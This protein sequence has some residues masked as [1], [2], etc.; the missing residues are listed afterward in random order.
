MQRGEAYEGSKIKE[1]IKNLEEVAKMAK[2]FKYAKSF[3]VAAI[4]VALIAALLVGSVLPAKAEPG[5]VI[6][7][8]VQAILTGPVAS[9]HLYLNYGTFDYFRYVNE[10]GGLNGVLIEDTWYDSRAEPAR[11][12]TT[13]RRFM[14]EGV[15]LEVS[16]ADTTIDP[17]VPSLPRDQIPVIM[18]GGS[19]EAMV[20]KPKPW[21]FS[22]SWPWG[23]YIP[24]VLMYIKEQWTEERPPRV[25]LMTID[26]S[27]IYDVLETVP[28]YAS[29]IGI[30][31]IGAELPS[32]FGTLD[33]MTEWMRLLSKNP[34][35]IIMGSFGQTQ[36][37]QLKNAATLEVAKK[38]IK[39]IGVYTLTEL[40]MAIA[41][42][43]ILEGWLVMRHMPS[44]TET[45]L[46]GMKAVLD[47]AKK[48]RGK[49]ATTEYVL[50][51]LGGQIAV[52]GIRLAI[53]RV[54]IQNLSGAAV[55]DAL[56]S[57]RDFDTGLIPPVT[58]TN[59]WTIF[60]PLARVYKIHD[61]KILRYS[62]DYMKFPYSLLMPEHLKRFGLGTPPGG[63]ISTYIIT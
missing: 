53:E 57:M 14:T 36:T 19:S 38:G 5:K 45:D 28:E 63:V 7:V 13:H 10:K 4:P 56:A 31:W 25:G 41:G 46:P 29:K 37:V 6:K 61:G 18:T 30:E 12:I 11:A 49:G 55:R 8:G 3:G 51:W 9:A 39:L 1:G 22:G 20:L 24:Y 2:M 26:Y 47:S 43:K 54:G 21:V 48:Y 44:V 58:M 33:T 15:V 42:K 32:M 62:E 50:G 16:Y 17:I 59:E 34:D 60:A 27:P 35:W 52:E 23:L 40:A